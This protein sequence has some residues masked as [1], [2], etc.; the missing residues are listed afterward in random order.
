MAEVKFDE[1]GHYDQDKVA[2]ID[3]RPPP[4]DWMDTPVD[5]REGS[6]IYPAKGKNL[7]YIGF[8]NPRQ[9]SPADKDWKLPKDW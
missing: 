7:E 6:W 4:T 3:Y 5:F 9:W 8:P 2:E 1:L